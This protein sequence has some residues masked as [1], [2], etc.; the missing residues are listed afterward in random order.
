MNWNWKIKFK[1]ANER[2]VEKIC[3]QR[4]G[5]C[6]QQLDS[7]NDIQGIESTEDCRKKFIDL[8]G[9]SVED[10]VGAN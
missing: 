4:R 9:Y 1:E 6:V 5:D 8:K 2:Y 3:Q 10:E 7:S